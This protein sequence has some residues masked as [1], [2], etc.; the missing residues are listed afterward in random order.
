MRELGSFSI[1][2]SPTPPSKSKNPQHLPKKT[3]TGK[4][5]IGSACVRWT[6]KGKGKREM[7]GRKK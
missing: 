4:V 3:D 2:L 6:V 5:D 1:K 7:I